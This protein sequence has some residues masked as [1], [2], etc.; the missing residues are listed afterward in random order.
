MFNIGRK[1]TVE[2]ILACVCI[3]VAAVVIGG[4]GI[5]SN[6]IGDRAADALAADD[7]N[8]GQGV[9]TKVV[10]IGLVNG[11]KVTVEQALEVP[12]R[13]QPTGL[14]GFSSTDWAIFAAAFCMLALAMATFAGA[15]LFFS[16]SE[17]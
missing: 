11:V 6:V 7:N 4:V 5:A 12:A 10:Q 17:W 2:F 13:P 16:P 8:L 15:R 1:Y 3:C 14:L 9:E